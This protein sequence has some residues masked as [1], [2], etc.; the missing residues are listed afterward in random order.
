VFFLLTS[1]A[2]LDA[3]PVLAA[4]APTSATAAAAVQPAAAAEHISKNLQST[5]GTCCRL[6]TLELP[7]PNEGGQKA[8]IQGT[9]VLIRC[10]GK[11]PRRA[12]RFT[13]LVALAF[14]VT[15]LVLL[16]VS[17]LFTEEIATQRKSREPANETNGIE[18]C[19]SVMYVL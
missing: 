4:T 19:L 14:Q 2:S 15:I 12:F 3:T 1:I 5:I 18:C 10:K 13:H 11:E 8:P 9:A 7:I 17:K 16:S 6:T